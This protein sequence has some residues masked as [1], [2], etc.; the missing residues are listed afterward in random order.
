MNNPP[1]LDKSEALTKLAARCGI[2]TE[3]E[4]IWGNAILLQTI[5]DKH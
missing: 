3:Y 4:D 2:A 5:P 1:K